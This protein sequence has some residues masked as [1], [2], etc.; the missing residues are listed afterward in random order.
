MSFMNLPLSNAASVRTASVADVDQL[1]PLFDACRQFYGDKSDIAASHR[2]LHARVVNRESLVLF[3]T[4][5]SVGPPIGLCQ[6]YPTFCSSEMAPIYVLADL[7][8]AANQR[9]TGIGRTLLIA[10]ERAG[11]DNGMARLELRTAH[12]NLIAQS[13]YESLGWQ[14]DTFFVAFSKRI[15]GAG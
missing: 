3:A 9:R 13:T 5:E 2:Y 11:A 15:A 10:A 6:L 8:V 7:Y 1:A 14:R 4:L 12:T